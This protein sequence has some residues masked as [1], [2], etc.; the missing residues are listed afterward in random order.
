MASRVA[1]I[2]VSDGG[3]L[4]DSLSL[5]NIGESNYSIKVNW[6]RDK[7]QEIRR[8]GWSRFSPLPVIANQ[9]V[10]DATDTVIKM[11]ELVRPN[12]ERV[13]LGAS[14]TEIKRFNNT[15]GI[16][17]IVGSNFSSSGKRWQV[18]TMNGFAVFNN[19]IDLPVTF[20]VED[21]AVVPMYE[22]REVGVASVGRMEQN[23]G[24]VL[25]ADIVEIQ[26]DQ[27]APWMNGY[28]AYTQTPE[29]KNANFTVVSPTDLGKRFDVTTGAA[30]ITATLPASPA[31]GFYF[32]IK[33]VDA[34]AGE[35]VTSPII[36]SQEPVL[37]T[38]GNLVLVR[39]DD[40]SVSWIATNF[41]AG[42]LPAYAPYGPVTIPITNHYPW[43]VINGEFGNPRN[44]A[45]VFSVYMA[46]ASATIVL[47]FPSQVFEAGV[48]RVAVINGGPA[49]GVLGGQSTTPNGV[50]V[51][52]VAGS[53]I[54]LEQS[55]D[56]G[57]TYPRVV[58]IVRWSDTSSLTSS[59]DLQDDGSLIHGLM[60][61]QNLVIVYR[62]T[63][64]YVGRYTG[65]SLD[66]NGNQ[67][68]PFTWR[69][70]YS[71]F[72][73]PRYG[74]CI[75]NIN[76]EFHLYPAEGGRFYMFDGNTNPVIHPTTDLARGF[77]FDDIDDDYEPWTI[78]NPLT[79]E[80]W[81]FRDGL[82][83]A[84]DFEWNT[85]SIIDTQIDAAVF[86]LRPNST[87]RWF[88]L[89]IENL[90]MTYG[91]VEGIVPIH[92]WL[93]D[94]EPSVPVIKSGLIAG[95]DQFNEK[96]LLSFVPVLASASPDMASQVDLYGC[97]NPSVT[98][99]ALLVPPEDLP[100]PEGENLVACFFMYTYFQY[101][102]TIT[103]E[104]DLDA[105]LSVILME[106]DKVMAG[107]VTTRVDQ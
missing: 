97:W 56:A 99:V 57:L 77:F 30:T 78:E 46:A 42:T 17:E 91:L 24:F 5:E 19:T 35:V 63:G 22:L 62:K 43:R 59:Y 18:I 107:R 27:L 66:E 9:H 80:W 3:A 70:R 11:A 41:E 93:R 100:N 10:F 94:G 33:K 104:R 28:A 15:T 83:F 105:R 101:Q 55:T 68:G 7:D 14:R 6:R 13:V 103:D 96:T 50:L 72:N 20:R 69:P 88:V 67:T 34:G 73:V 48:T 64:I 85:V 52:G 89:G 1:Q 51:T 61:L 76:G 16:W 75:A 98:P 87:D 90:I 2:K 39:W 102:L 84:Y 12:G 25:F 26:G 40:V 81:F 38:N 23:S 60:T 82:V 92:T 36:G 4:V 53:T 32:W 58:Q 49:G 65:L 45:P 95:G 86:C 8:E 21:S 74:D 44:W 54:T 106:Y 71:G 47:P 37:D 79:K 29:A 31:A